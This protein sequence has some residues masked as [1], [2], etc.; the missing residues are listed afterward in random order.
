M[1]IRPITS[2]DNSWV[3]QALTNLWGSTQM[4]SRGKLLE[5]SGLEGFIAEEDNRKVGLATYLV[6]NDTCE[7]TSIN[8]LTPGKGIGT[9]LIEKVTEI[10]KEKRC[11]TL[12]VITTNDNPQAVQFYEKNGFTITI[13]RKNI[14]DEYRKLKPGIPLIGN[15]GIPLTDEIELQK[16][17]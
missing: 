9:A 7:I 4:V 5:L 14:M 16:N 12:V 2:P 8:A 15:D 3:T 11:K 13:V 6:D 10:A 1:T 17:I